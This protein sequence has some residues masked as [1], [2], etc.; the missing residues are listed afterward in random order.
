MSGPIAIRAIA[1]SI[2]RPAGVGP[3][4]SSEWALTQTFAPTTNV[5]SADAGSLLRLQST[6]AALEVDCNLRCGDSTLRSTPGAFTIRFRIQTCPQNAHFAVDLCLRP[7]PGKNAPESEVLAFKNDRMSA[8]FS[9]YDDYDHKTYTHPVHKYG[10]DRNVPPSGVHAFS[11]Q[12]Y[13]VQFAPLPG[14]PQS[15]GPMPSF[16]GENPQVVFTWKGSNFA[17]FAFSRPTQQHHP[18][19]AAAAHIFRTTMDTMARSGKALYI[20]FQIK[21]APRMLECSWPWF[22]SMPS[23]SPPSYWAWVKG[24]GAMASEDQ[25]PRLIMDFAGSNFEL[26]PDYINK[27]MCLRDGERNQPQ[28]TLRIKWFYTSSPAENVNVQPD[29]LVMAPLPAVVR[30]LDHREYLFYTLGS[31]A[32]EE[33]YSKSNITGSYNGMHACELVADTAPGSRQYDV[34]LNIRIGYNVKTDNRDATAAAATLDAADEA[35][36][37]M[38]EQVALQV[39]LDDAI[40]LE[41]WRGKVVAM[42]ANHAGYNVAIRAVRP[43]TPGG[44]VLGLHQVEADFTFGH[45]GSS[46]DRTRLK[47]IELMLGL[48]TEPGPKS[49]LL[50]RILLAH[51]LYDFPE[52]DTEAGLPRGWR[53]TVAEVCAAA[54]LNTEQRAAVVHYFTHFLTIVKGPPGTG[55]STL[56][57]A[58]LELEERF[59]HKYWVCTDSNAAVDVLAEKVCKKKRQKHPSRFLRLRPMFDET[60]VPKQG[61]STLRITWPSSAANP[62]PPDPNERLMSL[63][64]TIHNRM[65]LSQRGGLTRARDCYWMS[66]V[67]DLDALDA[68]AQKLTDARLDDR[69]SNNEELQ[70]HEESVRAKFTVAIRTVQLK[71]T[72]AA[73]GIFSTAAAANGPLLQYAS[74]EGMIMD[75]ASQSSEARAVFP[76]VHALSGGRLKRMMLIG[77]DDQLPPARLAERNLASAAGEVSLM[78][79]LM[80]AGFQPVRLLEQFRMH[81][82]I[83]RIINSQIYG[84]QLRNASITFNRPEVAQFKGFVTGLWAQTRK[85]NPKAP[86]FNIDTCALVVSP[87]PY[88]AEFPV[89]GAEHMKGSSSRYNLQTA[90]MVFR[91]VGWLVHVSGFSASDILVTAYYADQVS[92]LKALM[93]STFPSIRVH[94]VDGSQGKEGLV[95]IV[96]CVTLGGGALPEQGM[97]FLGTDKRRFNVGG[98]RGMVGRIVFC[99]KDFGKGKSSQYARTNPWKAL[100]AEAEKNSWLLV[101]DLYHSTNWPNTGMAAK[102]GEVKRT[103]LRRAKPAA[104]ATPARKAKVGGNMS[105]AVIK[106]W[107]SDLAFMIAT[108]CQSLN[109][110]K[111]Y[112][113][114]AARQPD[115]FGYAI[116][117]WGEENEVDGEVEEIAREASD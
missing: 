11:R 87:S 58:I 81:E 52:N 109:Q 86:R 9:A 51:D 41:I 107:D 65:S 20:V 93:A 18:D 116:K 96:D 106:S 85:V 115:P 54:T 67:E 90:A 70:K 113:I 31:H 12:L 84:G 55:K 75:E 42:P 69:E 30:F 72:A 100:I 47:L 76:I 39:L 29:P 4:P 89:F 78:E 7:V 43:P 56:V 16:S 117:L 74:P 5:S 28:K 23:P 111:N 62:G 99:H 82:T 2:T 63:E 25:D 6:R 112:L 79:R 110:A 45:R 10:P 24:R 71:Y 108:N 22:A 44:R 26:Y 57:A 102:W 27:A 83:S 66:E 38:G 14:V 95:Q 80:L 103:F 50:K 92:L 40:G 53:D 46:W 37:D 94:T 3:A 21:S 64:Q 19:A 33:Q 36:P 101:D 34:L 17:K 32:Y 59:K 68:A 77:D 8:I 49:D 15:E 97:G 1:G 60:F 91:T 13:D 35:L 104:A 73:K 98:S 105:T 88:K 61:S 114:R 48:E